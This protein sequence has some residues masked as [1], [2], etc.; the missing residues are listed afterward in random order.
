[1]NDYFIFLA[2]NPEKAITIITFTKFLSQKSFVIV[3]FN[4][5]F[6]ITSFVKQ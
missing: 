6:G 4:S 2:K 1:M 5:G 3:H